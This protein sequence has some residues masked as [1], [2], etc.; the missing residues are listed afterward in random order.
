MKLLSLAKS[1][2]Y[3]C[4]ESEPLFPKA[5]VVGKDRKGRLVKRYVKAEL[6]AYVELIRGRADV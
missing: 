4:A 2:F 5:R 3:E 6:L 1:T